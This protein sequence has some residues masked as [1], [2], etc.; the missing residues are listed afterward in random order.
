MSFK[1]YFNFANLRLAWERMLRWTDPT[2]KDYWGIKVFESNLDQK[3]NQLSQKLINGEYAPIRPQ[4]FYVPKPSGTQ[5]TKT[6]LMVQDALVYQAIV[7]IIA[8]ESYEKLSEYDYCVF[9]NVLN[10]EVEEGVELLSSVDS[11]KTPTF[12]FF[13]SYPNLYNDFATFVNTIIVE[14]EIR[15]KLETDITGFFD[16]IPHF[17]LL[18]K[19]S[20]EYSVEDEILELLSDCLDCW[21]GTREQETFDIGIPQGPDPS[22]FLANIILHD[23][24]VLMEEKGV[25]GYCRYMDDIRI[26]DNDTN[27]LFSA[28]IEI[29]KYLK[30]YALS[31]NSS[32]TQIKEILDKDSDDSII[33]FHVD[34][35]SADMEVSKILD[36]LYKEHGL[37]D[38]FSHQAKRTT[39]NK[40]ITYEEVSGKEN[41][42]KFWK[43]ELSFVENRFPI[44]I[45]N[46]SQGQL[47]LI[48][49]KSNV[50][51]KFLDLAFKYRIAL[52]NLKSLINVEETESNGETP[53]LMSLVK[54][55]DIE[56]YENTL[57]Y[58]LFLLNQYPWRAYHYCMVLNEFP[59]DENLKKGLFKLIETFQFYEWTVHHLFLTLSISQKFEETELD[60]LIDSISR[61]TD[62]GKVGLYKLLIYHCETELL[63]SKL[64]SLLQKEPNKYLKK[65]LID[66]F[67]EKRSG[68]FDSNDLFKSF[69]L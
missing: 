18:S 39:K 46:N 58:W 26:Y 44:F 15:F 41:I 1:K 65:E 40:K 60:A 36:K 35:E 2:V 55:E 5:R 24:D 51:R 27:N 49:T 11:E 34:Y 42:I 10:E 25:D 61:Y 48:A 37:E 8:Y 20:D 50:E 66:F 57:K 28:M 67:I 52:Q 45:D 21:S 6:K 17:R 43:E 7:N 14:D 16:T 30:G 63:N 3:L 69:G 38:K 31:L 56:S 4:K 59:T 54:I 23:L 12:F 53:S 9:G 47:E 64:Y 68:N 29:D 22:F 13:K 33:D 32:K 19:L 62:Y